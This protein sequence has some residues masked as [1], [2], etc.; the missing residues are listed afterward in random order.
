MGMLEG[1]SFIATGT[2]NVSNFVTQSGNMEVA[3]S[4]SG[5]EKVI[6]ISQEGSD[7][8]N[9]T[10]AALANE[11]LRVF[12]PGSICLLKVT[13]AVTYGQ[14]LAPDNSAQ[15]VAIDESGT[16][17]APQFFAAIALESA[18]AGELCR[19]VVNLGYYTYHA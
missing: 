16:T 6:G 5:D 14:K 18:N 7:R 2:I 4:V 15:G 13:N 8:F 19:V 9:Q 10:Q 11:S 3:A 1:A 12:G 17:T